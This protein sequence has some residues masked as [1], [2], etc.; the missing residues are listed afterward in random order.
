[1]SQISK[2]QWCRALARRLD[3]LLHKEV[4]IMLCRVSSKVRCKLEDKVELEGIQLM[5][6]INLPRQQHLEL[7]HSVPTVSLC[8]QAWVALCQTVM[9]KAVYKSTKQILWSN[10]QAETAI[11]MQLLVRQSWEAPV[12]LWV[13]ITTETTFPT[14]L[15]T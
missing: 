1:M 6:P 2:V 12:V 8:I 5:Y 15:Q 11:L 9:H 13:N 3:S 10:L 4:Q 7:Q 14:S